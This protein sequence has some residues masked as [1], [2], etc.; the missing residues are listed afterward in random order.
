M[1]DLMIPADRE[2]VCMHR[3]FA[4]YKTCPGTAFPYGKFLGMLA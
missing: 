3:D 1:R 4:T 2:H